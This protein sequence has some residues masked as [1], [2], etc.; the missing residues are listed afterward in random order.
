VNGW[1]MILAAARAPG[2]ALAAAL[3][4]PEEQQKALLAL[5]LSDNAECEFGRAHRF[6]DLRSVADFRAAVPV[7]DYQ[8][9]G[10]A[11]ERIA[12]GAQGVLTRAPVVAFEE[13]GGTASG[14]KLIP[15]TAEGL[16]GFRA[17][18]LPWLADLARRRPKI[19]RGGVYISISP[20]TRAARKTRGGIPL[21][22]SSEAAYL[23]EDVVP[24]IAAMLAVPP[25]VAAIPDIDSWRL[26]TLRA[27]VEREDLSFVSVWSPTFLLGL[28]EA[29]P[30]A[31]RAL[32]AGLT[33]PAR[34][35]LARALSGGR[36]DTTALWPAL[37]T[38]SCWADGAS[39]VFSAR[40]AFLC[41]QALVEPKGLLA[42]EAAITLPWGGGRGN[43]PALTSAFIE[44]ID[45]A[46]EPRLAHQLEAGADYRVVITTMSGLYRYDIGDMLRCIGHDGVFPRLVFMG[47]GGLVS[48][49]VGEK[50][51]EAFVAEVFSDCGVIG[52]LVPKS[53]PNPHYELWLDQ[54]DEKIEAA[55]QAVERRLR[56]NPQYAYARD[57]RQL[58]PLTAVG[59][60][61]ICAGRVLKRAR[62]GHRLG[63]VKPTAIL[64]DHNDSDVG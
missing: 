10:P 34:R 49:L 50:L 23:G 63:D 33:E 31:E 14:G 13:T 36:I 41:P 32:A 55:A 45:S 15:Y 59:R 54:S 37:D 19:V 60:P 9:F 38:I 43:A 20:A 12:D 64:L 21:G 47:R 57:L 42:T 29:L 26:A 18:I 62:E 25:E 4:Q 22:L 6:S 28:V 5:I 11:I 44:F 51:D 56:A 17:A 24:A 1:Q 7:G 61:G 40:L 30:E 8:A 2:A 53:A 27:L 58:G 16:S 3:A 39:A 52:F 48:D 46:A 35:R